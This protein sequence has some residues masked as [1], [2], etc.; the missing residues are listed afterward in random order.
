MTGSQANFLQSLGWAALNSLWQMALL[1]VAY[2]LITGLLRPAKSSPKSWVASS[3]II[4]GFVWF[5]ATFIAALNKGTEYI[6]SSFSIYNI[7]ADGQISSW[8][9]NVLPVASIVYLILLI[10]PV[11]RFF[12]NYRYV[13]VIRRYGLSKINIE[14][15]I[16]V[17]K[18]A[19]RL[20]IK[21]TVKVWLSELVASP[22][23][24]GF[25]KPIILIPVAAINQLSPQQLEAVLLHELSHIKRHDYLINLVINIIRT[26]LYFNPFVIAFI[27]IIE[28]ERE[29][30]CDEMVLQFQYDSHEYASALLTLE[31]TNHAQNVFV[32]P[33]AGTNNDLLSRIEYILSVSKTPARP[34][35]RLAALLAGIIFITAVNMFINTANKKNDKLVANAIAA[36]PK[37]VLFASVSPVT[38]PVSELNEPAIISHTLT[39]NSKE[40]PENRKEENFIASFAPPEMM[41]AAFEFVNTP[42]L[43][44]Y[45]EE[46]V[47]KALE[48]SKKVLEES[49]WKSVEKNIA[50]VMTEKQ[51]EELK[52]IYLN[53][54]EKFDWK[55][56]ENRLRSVYDNVNWEKVN[57]Q[58]GNAITQIKV[59]SLQRVY[60][61]VAVKL[62]EV[63]RELNAR[64]MEGIPDSDITLELITDK[65]K[66]VQQILSE[67]K[68]LRNKKIVQL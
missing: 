60:N 68:G 33:A 43:K 15:R 52:K 28:S 64:A 12:R 23:T 8:L 26:I 56:W 9:L 58:L 49:Q 14:S 2:Q 34:F 22:V 4:A 6:N 30:S 61:D 27:K 53:E 45:Q 40:A 16:F 67:L 13:Q 39:K 1:W 66:I 35:K 38:E 50:D 25:L 19:G 42:E 10:F 47:K 51:K 63:Q 21:K 36:S 3:M 32:V 24:I 55:K 65:K 7:D 18:I 31:K 11:L 17:Q 59:D 29:K 41:H 20:G 5:V 48:E 57:L 54:I 62:N 46:Q 37:Q 44:K